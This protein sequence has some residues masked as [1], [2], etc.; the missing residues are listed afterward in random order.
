MKRDILKDAMKP[1]NKAIMTWLASLYL[2]ISVSMA[3]AQN[4]TAISVIREGV[5]IVICFPDSTKRIDTMSI[6][7]FIQSQPKD[8]QQRNRNLRN[9]NE[10]MK[11]EP[12]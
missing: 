6:E 1:L 11:K 12:E 4:D 3:Y 9:L 7:M 10:M 2:S 5:R 8:E